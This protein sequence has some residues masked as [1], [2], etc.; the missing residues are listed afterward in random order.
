[1]LLLIIALGKWNYPG[2]TSDWL[3]CLKKLVIPWPTYFS[4]TILDGYSISIQALI[5]VLHCAW[6]MGFVV[7][8]VQELTKF[9][10]NSDNWRWSPTERLPYGNHSWCW[11]CVLCGRNYCFSIQKVRYCYSFLLH[12]FHE[13]SW[14]LWLLFRTCMLW[15]K[16]WVSIFFHH[17]VFGLSDGKETTAVKWPTRLE[18]RTLL[19]LL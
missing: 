13:H 18:S 3:P 7:C 4:C 5:N 8:I 17:M 11:C 2:I 6:V 19:R 16:S 1:M 14:L 9:S 15:M 12:I 10:F